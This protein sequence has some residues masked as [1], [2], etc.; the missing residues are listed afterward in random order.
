MPETERIARADTE[1]SVP[2]RE[3]PAT[4][5]L[6]VIGSLLPIMSRGMLPF[7]VRSWGEHGDAFRVPLP[8]RSV[9]VLVHPAAVEHMLIGAR[10]NYVKGRTYDAMRLLTGDGVLTLEGSDWRA[11]RRLEQ[12]AFHREALTHM[13]GRMLGTA[14]DLLADWRARMP[15]G[16]T[17][18]VHHEMLRLTLDIVFDALF[19]QTFATQNVAEAGKAFD[20]V[21]TIMY[22]RVQRPHLPLRIPTPSNLRFRRARALLDALVF[23]TIER[24]RA[25]D[26]ESDRSTLL[27]MLLHA[28][29][30]D[31]GRAL[32]DTEIRNDVITLFLA[33]HETTAL[34]LTWA[35]ILLDK[36]PEVV[37][38]IRAELDAVV[39]NRAP[40]PADLPK[41]VY[42]R[43]VIDEVLRL[44]PPA[45]GVARDVVAPDTVSGFAIRPRDTAMSVAYL[46]HRHPEFWEQPER[47]DPSRFEPARS[48]GRHRYA[49]YPFSAGPR[50][51]IGNNF[52]LM[53]SQVALATLLQRVDL[54]LDPGQRID[55]VALITL[56]PSGPVRAQLHWRRL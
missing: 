50:I 45:W 16:G 36:H 37:A 53:E 43:Q 2:P 25:G 28:R 19:G 32:T 47:F 9:V 35:M 34:L 4:R 1:L 6:P 17:L 26:A 49:Y 12:P 11:R 30:A 42:L 48:Q 20:R 29:D 13:T 52:A 5:G 22:Q 55:P 38:Q 24:A 41:L 44:Q 15:N 18:D 8:D 14:R 51:C 31:D 46:T 21:L 23:R 27:S 54:Q 40:E 7:L 39:G 10:D 3:L 56:R 33:G